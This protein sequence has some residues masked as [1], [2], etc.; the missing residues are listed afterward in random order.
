MTVYVTTFEVTGNFQFPMDM[1]RYDRCFPVRS[2]DGSA[3]LRSMEYGNAKKEVDGKFRI[4]LERVTR[5]N[6]DPTA[7][8]WYSFGWVVDP[9][10][11]KTE[12]VSR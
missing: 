8:R 7:V 11:V 6:P 4:R 5:G 9:E 2:E 12:K 1:L 10:T 3:I